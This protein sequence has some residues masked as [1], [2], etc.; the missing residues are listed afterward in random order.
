MIMYASSLSQER[1]QTRLLFLKT[2]DLGLENGRSPIYSH[3]LN[4]GTGI[5]SEWDN[6]VASL[7]PLFNL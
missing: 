2:R 5:T 7:S 4:Q 1:E 6:A 3:T